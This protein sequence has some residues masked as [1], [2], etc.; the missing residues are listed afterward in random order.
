MPSPNEAIQQDVSEAPEDSEEISEQ[1]AKEVAEEQELY[2]DTE[3]DRIAAER[4][5]YLLHEDEEDNEPDEVVELVNSPL[6]ERDGQWYAIAKVN[7]VEQEIPWD[8]VIT[9]MTGVVSENTIS[10]EIISPSGCFDSGGDCNDLDT[11]NDD[12]IDAADE[13][14]CTATGG[15]WHDPLCEYLVLTR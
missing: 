9:L 13:A 10:L 5:Q 14:A 15:S 6:T 3:A 7:G 11:E 1:E 8:E 4:E 2:R 12:E